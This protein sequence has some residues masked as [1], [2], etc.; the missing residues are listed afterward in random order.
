[1]KTLIFILTI[2][3]SFTVRASINNQFDANNSSPEKINSC[4]FVIN[5]D[6]PLHSKNK[7]NQLL[8]RLN[9][10]KSA[11]YKHVFNG[12]SLPVACDK[13]SKLLSK[14]EKKGI[15]LVDDA[16]VSIFNKGKGSGKNK[17][18]TSD[19]NTVPQISPWQV[20]YV[21]GHYSGVG[22]TVWIIDTGIDLNN[23]DLNIN[24]SDGFSVFKRGR[25]FLMNDDNGHGTHVAGIVAAK[26]N[27]IDGLGIAAGATVVPVRVLDANGSGTMSGVLSGVE[28]VAQ[29]AQ[30]GDCVNMSLGGTAYPLLDQAIQNAANLSRAYFTLAAGNSGE[31]ANTTSP[32]RVNGVNIYTISANNISDQ[33]PYWSNYGNP[34]IDYSAPGVNIPSLKIGGG[35]ISLSGTSMAAPV[36]CGVLLNTGGQPNHFKYI[37]NDIDNYPDPIIS[38]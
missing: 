34:P 30:S 28:H 3:T 8:Q 19:P 25:R 29:Y 36:A 27:D 18:S 9:I 6:T 7:Q 33:R 16:S 38:H 2:F 10:N 13:V 22:L 4:I 17:D 23:A 32:A 5:N 14:E 12:F 1:M 31:H 20:S 21:G 37:T 35:V 26:D 24:T 11:D 15:Q